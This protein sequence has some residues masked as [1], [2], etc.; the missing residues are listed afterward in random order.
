LR[1][2]FALGVE[3]HGVRVIGP[4][5][6]KRDPIEVLLTMLV[7]KKREYKASAFINLCRIF[8]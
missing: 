2:G 8:V 1:D 5:P 3:A 6:F 4:A 7:E